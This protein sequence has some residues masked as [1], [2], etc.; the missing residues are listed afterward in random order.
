MKIPSAVFGTAAITLITGC[1]APSTSDL[2]SGSEAR[3]LP[4]GAHLD[5][6]GRITDVGSFPLA[7][8]PSPDGRQLVLLLNG[9]RDQGIEIVDRGTGLVTQT[10]VQPAAFIGLVFSP[11]GKRLYASGGNED[12]IYAYDWSEGRATLTDT[13]ILEH[14]KPKADGRR[15]PAGIGI[16]PDGSTLYVAENL[17]DSVAVIDIATRSVTQRLATERYPYGVTVSAAGTVYVAAWGGSTVSAFTPRGKSLAAAARIPVARHPSALLLNGDGSRLFVVSASTDGISVVDT[18]DRKAIATISVANAGGPVEGA[19]PNALALSPDGKRLYVAEADNNAVSI[20]NLSAKSSGIPTATGND[21]VA[22]RIPS[23]WYPSGVVVSRDSLFVV[24]GKGRGTGPNPAGP[25]SGRP[26][27]KHSYTL[28]QTSGTVMSMSLPQ[29]AIDVAQYSARVSRANGWNTRKAFKY[30]PIEHV[31]YIIKENRTYDQILGDLPQADGDTSLVFFPR[32]VSPNHH[33]L[34]ERFGIFDRFFVNAEVSADGH[35]WSAGAYVTDYVEKTVASRYSDRGR[36]YDYEGSNRNSIPEDDAAEPAAGYLWNLAERSGI[37]F[38]NYG[39][40][41]VGVPVSGG[42]KYRGTK[43]YLALHTNENYPG[44]DLAISDQRRVDVWLADLRQFEL[45]RG[46]PALQIMRLPNDHT[47]GATAGSLTPRAYMADNDLA[48]GRVV[49]ALSKSSFW[50]STAVF[51]LEDDAQNGSDHV[52]SH[53][54]PMIVISPWTRGGVM[55]R[56]TNTTDVI[57]TIEELLHLGTLSQFDHYGR[58]LRDIWAST[59]NVAPYVAL[60]PSVPLNERNPKTGALAEESKKLALSKEDIA[61]ED[62]FNRILWRTIKG[63]SRPWPGVR[64][65]PRGSDSR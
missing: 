45:D 17:A 8:V 52:D 41:V 37:T 32:P 48:L 23:G 44:Y 58:P 6:A 42:K 49:E 11:D 59:P 36:T 51:V 34:A 25:L 55:H 2:A 18:R 5:P 33:A 53:R 13:L 3:R 38:R 4:T 27:D 47:M 64:K 29:T 9:Y 39:E 28:G 60:I 63:E 54:S 1:S 19:T 31:I 65:A 22:G 15:Y 30:P 40:F 10:L 12:A 20:I 43:P 24:N 7:M 46:M 62:L 50:R 26:S 61:E 56:F 16:S 14:K 57:A 21:A 35:N